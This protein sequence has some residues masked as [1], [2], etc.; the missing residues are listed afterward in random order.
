MGHRQPTMVRVLALTICLVAFSPDALGAGQNPDGQPVRL[1][2]I[3]HLYESAE[4]D[5]ALAAVARVNPS[6]MAPAEARDIEVYESLCLLALGNTSEAEKTIQAVLRADPL[7]EPSG[8][9]PNR[10]RALVGAVRDRIRPAL[11]QAHYRS[12]RDLFQA[13]NYRGAAEEFSLVLQLTEG[14]GED[15]AAQFADL[16][17]LAGSFLELA[18]RAMTPA[19]PA[20]RAQDVAGSARAAGD[21]SL[22]APLVIRQDVPSWPASLAPV[23]RREASG[24]LSGILDVTIRPDGTVETARI[25][26]SIHPMYDALLIAAASHWKYQPASR[27]GTAVEYVKRLAINVR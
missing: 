13:R 3:K 9:L 22:I 23:L 5:R 8:D 11:A 26:K 21:D 4:Y 25:I 10:L 15:A 1:T 18:N 16:R 14:R 24:T 6:A 17:V 12:G 19:A 2:D 20:P 27:R 7:Y